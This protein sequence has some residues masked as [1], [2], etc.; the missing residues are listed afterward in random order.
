MGCRYLWAIVIICLSLLSAAAQEQ[1]FSNVAITT[2]HVNGHVYLLS[3]DC[4][5]GNIGASV[6]SDGI[7]IVDDQ[8]APLA[9]KIRTALKNIGGGPLKFILNTHWHGDHTG[10]NRVFGPEALIIA[11]TNVRKR[12]S[13]EQRAL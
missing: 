13:T 10:S 12:L 6:G 3:G 7:L 1:D 8:F 11:H 9:E 2:T 5:C 4:A